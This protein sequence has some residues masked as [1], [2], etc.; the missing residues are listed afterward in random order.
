MKTIFSNI[1]RNTDPKLLTL[2]EPGVVDIPESVLEPRQINLKGINTDMIINANLKWHRDAWISTINKD[3]ARQLVLYT[4]AEYMPQKLLSY[5]REQYLSDKDVIEDVEEFDRVSASDAE[6]IIVAIIG[7]NRSTLSVCRNIVSG[8]QD[9]DK[10]VSDAEGAIES[11][12][13]LLIED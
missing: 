13:I 8:C 12:S 4:Q 9:M 3:N 6:L 1:C 2:A 7:D 11:A 5:T 10:V